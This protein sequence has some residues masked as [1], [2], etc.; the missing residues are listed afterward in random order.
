LSDKKEHGLR[1]A[2]HV[3]AYAVGFALDGG[4]GQ[5]LSLYY[6]YF[7]MYAMGLSPILAGLVAGLTKIWD[8]VIDPVIGVLVDKTH[9]KWGKCRPWLLASVVPVFVTYSLLWTNLG[10]QGQWA[11][12]FYFIFAYILFSTASSI[13]I[14]PYDAL[15]PRMVDDYNDRTDY[16]SYRM[17]FSGI[18]SV[19]ST[20]IYEALIP[21]KTT[22]DYAGYTHNFAILG[23]VL[24]VMF[25]LPLL[26]TFLGSKEKYNP[27]GEPHYSFRETVRGY[28]ELLQSKLYRKCYAMTMLG[29]FNQYAIVSTLVIFVLLVYSNLKFGN[30]TLTFLTVN[31]KGALEIAFFIP[32]VI[33][34]KK[35]N[36]HFPLYFDL[37]ILAAGLLILLFVTPKAPVWLFLLGVSLAG[38]GTSCLGFVPAALMPDLPDVDEL[39]FGKRRE[40]VSAGFVKMGKQVVQGL[41]FLLFSVLLTAFGLDETNTSPEQATFASLAAVKIMLC[42][43]P[44]LASLG[45]LLL[46]RNYRLNAETY[47]MIKECIAQKRTTGHADVP[48][49][50][51]AVLED[52]TGLPYERLWIAQSK[53]EEILQ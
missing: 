45:M 51:R 23:M 14:V 27:A 43:I 12:F 21:V 42:V 30:F 5:V 2:W 33:A 28:G 11:K 47:A 44:V 37:P 39:I 18:A 49:D 52:I 25:A 20:Y 34:M 19:A 26:V 8:G 4:V 38:A 50:E 17:I 7:L 53:R 46:S 40:G 41:A 6:L 13:G 48:D 3:T 16:S 9:T 10:L 22:A 15:L 29:A 1:K 35:R 31:L 36:K 32:N 24:G